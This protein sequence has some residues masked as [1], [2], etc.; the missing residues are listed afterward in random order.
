MDPAAAWSGLLWPVGEGPRPTK[1][2]K[3]V[4]EPGCRR[5][6]LHRKPAGAGC[7]QNW[8]PHSVAAFSTLS[9]PAKRDRTTDDINRSSVLPPRHHR[10]FPLWRCL[11]DARDGFHQ[12][13]HGIRVAEPHI[14]LAVL[15]EAPPVQRS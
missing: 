12:V 9:L 6:G 11:L 4:W 8:P 1:F 15:A 5:A 7:G 10:G 14:A 13:V 3:K 2:H